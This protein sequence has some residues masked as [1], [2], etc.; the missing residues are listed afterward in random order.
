[1]AAQ[2]IQNG[3][4]GTE[5]SKIARIYRWT[6]QTREVIGAHKGETEM[7]DTYFV[8]QYSQGK[9]RPCYKNYADTKE[10]A[11]ERYIDLKTNWS[12]KEVEVLRIT[13]RFEWDGTSISHNV[14]VIAE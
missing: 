3:T 2:H 1:M 5:V 13:E 10:E 8:I 9:Y 4:T 6:E 12:Y 7:E 14:E 11:M